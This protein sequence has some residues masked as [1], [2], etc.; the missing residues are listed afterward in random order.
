MLVLLERELE[1]ETIIKSAATFF[2][3]ID[4]KCVSGGHIEDALVSNIL[5][6]ESAFLNFSHIFLVDF[7]TQHLH[8]RCLILIVIKRQISGII[9]LRNELPFSF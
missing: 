3:F 8:F 7:G 2:N 9:C 6:L 4:L 1:K 5:E